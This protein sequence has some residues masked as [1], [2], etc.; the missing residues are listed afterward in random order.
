MWYTRWSAGKKNK[1][2]KT[3]C[4]FRGPCPRVSPRARRHITGVFPCPAVSEGLP[5]STTSF[6]NSLCQFMISCHVYQL[7]FGIKA[8]QCFCFWR[9]G[10]ENGSLHFPEGKGCGKGKVKGVSKGKMKSKVKGKMAKGKYYA[11]GKG[12]GST[13]LGAAAAP[14]VT[15]PQLAEPN[16]TVAHTPDAP[17]VT[18][19]PPA[20]PEATLPATLP[21]TMPTPAA[22]A[23]ECANVPPTLTNEGHGNDA[24]T[25]PTPSSEDPIPDQATTAKGDQPT[26]KS[27]GKGCNGKGKKGKKGKG[28]PTTPN[29]PTVGEPA[30]P[31]STLATKGEGKN[32][33]KGKKGLGKAKGSGKTKSVESTPATSP[34]ETTGTPSSPQ[35]CFLTVA[36]YSWYLYCMLACTGCICKTIMCW[37]VTGLWYQAGAQTVPLFRVYNKLLLD[38]EELDHTIYATKWDGGKNCLYFFVVAPTSHEAASP[39][40]YKCVTAFW[41]IGPCGDVPIGSTWGRWPSQKGISLNRINHTQ[42]IL[43]NC[44]GPWS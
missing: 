5:D 33:A 23:E 25:A 29:Q 1:K 34:G 16:D 22:E 30:T 37:G 24:A 32:E 41:W 13:S 6:I 8:L 15:P 10:A 43:L 28:T 14:D 31:P 36:S 38:H 9:M 20:E 19:P 17:D 11:P 39:E 26:G 7:D 4:Y 21:D 27:K 44:H 42:H 35:A 12:K 3:N 2:N 18:G 40:L